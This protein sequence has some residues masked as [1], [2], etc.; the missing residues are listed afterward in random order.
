VH[1]YIMCVFRWRPWSSLLALLS[2]TAVASPSV[3]PLTLDQIMADPD[4]I[5]PK[6]NMKF[7]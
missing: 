7:S 6:V 2:L 5:G 4:W 3:S 1:L